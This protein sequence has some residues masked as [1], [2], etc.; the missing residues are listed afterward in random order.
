MIRDLEVKKAI[1]GDINAFENIIESLKVY[2]YAVAIRYLK[3]EDDAGDAIGNTILL[4]YENLNKLKKV[5]YFKTWLT[6]ILINE[7]HKILSSKKKVLLTEDYDEI[8]ETYMESFEDEIDISTYLNQLSDVQKAVILMY[9]YEEL[10]IEEIAVTLKI[11][12]GTVKSRLF[13]AKKRL[14]SM[15]ERKGGIVE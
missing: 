11:A 9:Y 13:H 12:T 14:K 5:E 8:E 6:R 7:C 4:A 3:N 10:S 2:M 1:N 15:L